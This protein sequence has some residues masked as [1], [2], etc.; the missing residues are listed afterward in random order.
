MS[1]LSKVARFVA[2]RD[3][4]SNANMKQEARTAEFWLR[5]HLSDIQSQGYGD[6]TVNELLREEPYEDVQP[7]QHQQP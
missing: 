7:T 5:S 4:R 6:M 3:Q 1:A 2:E